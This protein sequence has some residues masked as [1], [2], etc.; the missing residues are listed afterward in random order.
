MRKCIYYVTTSVDGYIALKD[1][2]TS[3]MSGA[4]RS[5]YGFSEFYHSVGTIIMGRK[6]YE[7]ILN[8]S[9]G[10][11]FPYEDKEVYV[12]T[13]DSDFRPH[14]DDIH[15]ISHDV[16]K[17]IARLKIQ[18]ADGVLWVAGGSELASFLFE[19]GLLDEVH[20]FVQ[21][22]VLGA[23]ISLFKALKRPSSLRLESCEKWPGDI[24]EL[25]YQTVKSWRVD[26]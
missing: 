12:V 16:E 8:M 11:Y 21:P 18:N 10:E 2:S 13:H 24:V 23:G 26:I 14:N 25:R 17:E 5:D 19:E 9:Q 7:K 1:G 6:T 20:V 3:W 22:I 15:V 4:P